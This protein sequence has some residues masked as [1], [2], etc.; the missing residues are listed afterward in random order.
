MP[1]RFTEAV[2]EAGESDHFILPFECAEG[3][4]KT[5][6]VFA[7]IKQGESV[8]IFIG[9]E[10]GFSDGEVSIAEE[11]GAVAITLGKRILRTETAAMYVLSVLGFLLEK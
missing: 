7:G 8:A 3:F 4:D 2:A 9:P 10:G 11:N 5:R 6:E 1:V